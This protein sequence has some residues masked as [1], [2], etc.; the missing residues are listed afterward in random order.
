MIEIRYFIKILLYKII[1]QRSK[2]F[3]TN[4]KDTSTSEIYSVNV[5]NQTSVF[6]SQR[7]LLDTSSAFGHSSNHSPLI[8]PQ[9]VNSPQYVAA[10]PVQPMIAATTFSNQALIQPLRPT[11]EYIPSNVV[12][13]STQ[14]QIQDQLQKKH[15]ELKHLIQKQ[16]EELRRVSEQLMIARYG[17]VPT[18]VTS[19]FPI[20][21][22]D[23][24]SKN[25]C[26]VS[27]ISSMSRHSEEASHV[28]NSNI[29]R[30]HFST[31]DNVS[32]EEKIE[33]SYEKNEFTFNYSD[34][35]QNLQESY[36]RSIEDKPSVSSQKTENEITTCE[37]SSKAF[38]KSS[39]TSS[40][41]GSDLKEK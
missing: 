40:I 10:I 21:K 27:H 18:L 39:S 15:E 9:F 28:S 8:S 11:F 22:S 37:I 6:G 3:G 19:H 38:E 20:V 32:T 31:H 29:K 14:N 4:F 30:S 17:I 25:S 26:N 1:L 13:T 12:L 5:Q 2:G 41:E 33:P 24:N 36:T 34:N 7:S 35:M 23:S 16:Q